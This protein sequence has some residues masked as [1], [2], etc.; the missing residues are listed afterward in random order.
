MDAKTIISILVSLLTISSAIFIVVLQRKTERI[1]I[2]ENQLSEKKYKAYSEL[3]GIF[4]NIFK[5][6]KNNT[7]A[8]NGNLISQLID[9]KKDLFIYGSDD[10]FRKFTTWLS[11]ST[12]NQNDLNHMNYFLDLMLEIRKDMGKKNTSLTKNE[13]MLNLIQDKKV[14]DEFS[15]YWK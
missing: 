2:I 7:P 6:V 12:E 13:I 3:V 8:D 11:F 10:V 4:Y 9:V 15:E 14:L 5:D 1:K